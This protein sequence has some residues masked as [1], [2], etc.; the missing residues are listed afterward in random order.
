M[1]PSDPAMSEP[2]DRRPLLVVALVLFAAAA[3]VA[4]AAVG[5]TP[6][7]ARPDGATVLPTT[8]DGVLDLAGSG[9]NLPSMRL[10][11]RRFSD[12]TGIPVRVHASIGSSGGL[13]ALRARVVDAALVSR[14]LRPNERAEGFEAIPYA[15]TPVV[16][17]VH[18]TVPLRSLDAAALADLIAG[19]VTTWP[20]GTPVVF[21]QREPGDSSFEILAKAHPEVAEADARARRAH[22]HPVAVHDADVWPILGEMPGA[23]AIVAEGDLR[24]H[25]DVRPVTFEGKRPTVAAVVTGRYPYR[26]SLAL[27]LPPDAPEAL[28]RLAAFVTSDE[29]RTLLREAGYAPPLPTPP[30]P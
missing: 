13:A 28:R 6:P 25:P 7:A 3:T 9:S 8:D 14:P 4:W 26:K 23:I 10:L 11:A 17:A 2:W 27:V 29:A 19:R 20:D 12:A 15:L 22:L 16:V 1:A 24:H 30:A 21:V 18:R 5:P